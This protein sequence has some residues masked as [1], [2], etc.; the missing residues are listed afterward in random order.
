MIS[1]NRVELGQRTKQS[2]V[3]INSN[4]KSQRDELR[5]T[6]TDLTTTPEHV[7]GEQ[8]GLGPEGRQVRARHGERPRAL[9]PAALPRPLPRGR[10]LTGMKRTTLLGDST[11]RFQRGDPHCSSRTGRS[12]GANM[13]RALRGE[14][15]LRSGRVR[16]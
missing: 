3:S 11:G 6:Y 15:P 7:L 14:S 16:A 1:K 9:G 10:P 2:R 8:I 13:A 4:D 12:L 5:E